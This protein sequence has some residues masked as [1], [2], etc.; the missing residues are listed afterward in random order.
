MGRGDSVVMAEIAYKSF[1]QLTTGDKPLLHVYPPKSK[2]R[3]RAAA[4]STEGYAFKDYIVQVTEVGFNFMGVKP[5]YEDTASPPRKQ[6]KLTHSPSSPHTGLSEASPLALSLS[7]GQGKHPGYHMPFIA[8]IS[9]QEHEVA[10]NVFL[11]F[12]ASVDGLLATIVHLRSENQALQKEN[13]EIGSLNN[14]LQTDYEYNKNQLLKLM[15]LA[16]QH[17]EMTADLSM[18][19][20]RNNQ[21]RLLEEQQQLQLRKQHEQQQVLQQQSE[22]Q[23]EVQQQMNFPGHYMPSQ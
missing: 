2:P 20:H 11:Y 8:F 9:E 21:E 5:V 16:Q 15:Q 7:H 13:M 3:T 14:A 17:Q 19:H 10:N 12:K 22:H 23:Q 4:I 6:R 18:Q 1:V